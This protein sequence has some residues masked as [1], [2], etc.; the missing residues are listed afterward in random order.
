MVQ[1][2]DAHSHRAAIRFI[3]AMDR[4]VDEESFGGA[5]KTDLK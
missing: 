2:M 3:R 5:K 4:D 1:V